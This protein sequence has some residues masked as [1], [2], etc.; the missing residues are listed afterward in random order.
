MRGRHERWR[1]EM[2]SDVVRLALAKEGVWSDKD[3]A[4]SPTR[5]KTRPRPLTTSLHSIGRISE[6]QSLQSISQ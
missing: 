1:A 4:V 3:E 5:S 6:L 2:G